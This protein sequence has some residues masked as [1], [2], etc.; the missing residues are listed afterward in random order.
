MTTEPGKHDFE[1][2]CAPGASG[3][4]KNSLQE[5][6]SV[7][8]FEWVPKSGGKGHK[9]GA[10][11]V[12]VKGPFHDPEKVYSKARA[13]AGELDAGTYVGPKNVTVA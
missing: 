2:S 6:F 11:K 10:V 7:G 3:V 4:L 8:I 13:I 1:G 12:R 5:T 9:R